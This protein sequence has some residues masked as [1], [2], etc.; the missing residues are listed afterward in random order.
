[1]F[2]IPTINP[3]S[4]QAYVVRQPERHYHIMPTDGAEVPN[5][6]YYRQRIKDGTLMPAEPIQP[7]NPSK[8][9]KGD[10]A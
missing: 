8:A 2:V 3:E 7:A 1:M 5:D 10:D 6:R 9:K 4:G